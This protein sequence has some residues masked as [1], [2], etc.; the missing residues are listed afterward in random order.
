[1]RARFEAFRKG[2]DVAG[3]VEGLD[4]APRA[5]DSDRIEQLEEVEVEALE[6]AGGGALLWR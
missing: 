4:V 2:A 3:V 5:G 6:D 1:M